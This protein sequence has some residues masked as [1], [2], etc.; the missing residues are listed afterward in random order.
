MDTDTSKAS[1]KPQNKWRTLGR[2]LCVLGFGGY[3]FEPYGHL[4]GLDVEQEM[5]QLAVSLCEASFWVGVV[6][7]SA[8]ASFQ[9]WRQRRKEN[10]QMEKIIAA[11]DDE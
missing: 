10:E 11:V 9:V 7:L 4:V 8:D 1:S 2:W 6:M 3:I 5:A